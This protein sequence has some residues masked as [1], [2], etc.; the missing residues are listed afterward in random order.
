M[1]FS[2]PLTSRNRL[3]EILEYRSQLI[4]HTQQRHGKLV[5][6][7]RLVIRRPGASHAVLCCVA[8]TQTPFNDTCQPLNFQIELRFHVIAHPFVDAP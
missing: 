8:E 6:V 2:P 3:P 5:R 7:G 1:S 4:R